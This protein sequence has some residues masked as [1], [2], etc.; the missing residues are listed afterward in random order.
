[1]VTADNGRRLQYPLFEVTL[2]DSD[3]LDDGP[4]WARLFTQAVGR[5]AEPAWAGSLVEFTGEDVD[6]HASVPVSVYPSAIDIDG[7]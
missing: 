4:V 2:D 3:Y 7:G 1:V 5:D 6:D